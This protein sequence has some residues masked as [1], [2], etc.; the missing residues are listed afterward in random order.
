MKAGFE[1]FAASHISAIHT[2]TH[3]HTHN[4]PHKAQFHFNLLA[5]EFYIE[6]LAHAVCKM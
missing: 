1:F 2:L 6:I 5:L 4:M 3:T